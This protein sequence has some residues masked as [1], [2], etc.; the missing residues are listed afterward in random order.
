MY[1]TNPNINANVF[2]ANSDNDDITGIA[3]LAKICYSV[4]KYRIVIVEWT[5]TDSLSGQVSYNYFS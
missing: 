1:T 3:Y 2:F 5:K 4:L